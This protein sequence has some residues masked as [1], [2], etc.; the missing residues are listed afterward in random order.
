M[1]RADEGMGFLLQYENVAWYEG[2][3]VRILDRRIY[4][5]K[6]EFVVCRSY[7]E[8]AQAIAD[9]VT[10]SAGPYT[11]AAMGMALA[12]YEVR[13]KSIDEIREYLK[14]A[15]YAL[16]HARPTTSEKCSLLQAAPWKQPKN[17]YRKAGQDNSLLMHCR[18]MHLTILMIP[19]RNICLQGAIWQK[20]SLR[21]GR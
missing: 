3:C 21:A 13:Q 19:I 4:P 15:E 18:N 20:R 6:T 8:V 5:V 12:A 17:A 14:K 1:K 16:S 9:M 2:G 11:A 7:T 10:Q